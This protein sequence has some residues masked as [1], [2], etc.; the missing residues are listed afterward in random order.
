MLF[1]YLLKLFGVLGIFLDNDGPTL[2]KYLLNLFAISFASVMISTPS[3]NC[4]GKFCF[5]E[6]FPINSFMML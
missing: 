6:A 5:F 2:I 1:R 3:L 4:D